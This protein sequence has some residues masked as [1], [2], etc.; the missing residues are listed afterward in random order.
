[1]PCV[2]GRL[3]RKVSVA[4]ATPSRSSSGSTTIAARP[5]NPR[6]PVVV[7]VGEATNSSPPGAKRSWRALPTLAKK[8]AQKPIGRC[9]NERSEAFD[10]PP[11]TTT[12]PGAVYCTEPGRSQKRF[13]PELGVLVGVAGA[14]VSVGV[15]TGIAVAV[16]V[17]D[18]LADA[19]GVAG[20][21]FSAAPTARM[22]SLTLTMPSPFSSMAVQDDTAWSPSAI[23]T[24]LIRSSI[25]TAPSPAQ[26]PGQPD[27]PPAAAGA[28][29]RAMHMTVTAATITRPTV[30]NAHTLVN[31]LSSNPL[32]G[33]ASV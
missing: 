23:L 30:E 12:T 15:D 16:S 33:L 13:P 20:Q 17:S 9:R 4:S 31:G 2:A 27:N 32:S 6:P 26:S 7:C 14:T 3:S 19:V 18:G 29:A 10:G 21:P 28:G 11:G 1:M 24:P 22:S 5:E 8:W 25:A